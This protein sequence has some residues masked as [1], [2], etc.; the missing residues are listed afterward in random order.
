MRAEPRVRRYADHLLIELHAPAPGPDGLVDGVAL[1]QFVSRDYVV[2]VHER[3][4][5]IAPDDASRDTTTV[6]RRLREGRAAAGS[7]SQLA[8]AVATAVAENMEMTVRGLS[9]RVVKLERE[10]MHGRR[11]DERHLD[12][13][14]R[15]RHELVT[16]Q[17][18]AT[19]NR[20][21]FDRLSRM[22]GELLPDSMSD[23]EDAADQFARVQSM[24]AAERDFLQELL[25]LYQTRATDSINIAMERL[26]LISAVALPI[27][28]VAS[29]NGMNTMVNAHTRPLQLV[30]SLGAVVLTIAMLVW[31]RRQGWW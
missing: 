10:I 24:C 18:M 20:A 1:N 28:A 27:T 9:D 25:D 11:S 16:V 30:L 4:D 22:A 7:S 26:A 31:A 15:A 3:R 23:V 2:T 6:L 19:H 5:G 21:V 14:F 12:S 17:T 29:V 8:H 13:M